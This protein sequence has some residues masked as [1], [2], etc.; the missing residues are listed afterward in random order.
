MTSDHDPVADRPVEL[1]RFGEEYMAGLDPNAEL[2][3]YYPV[4][5]EKTLSRHEALR[6]ST[7][8]LLDWLKSGWVRT[9]DPAD[10]F[11]PEWWRDKARQPAEFALQQARQ[12]RTALLAA[13]APAEILCV[14]GESA[15]TP[16][17]VTVDADGLRWLNTSEGDGSTPWALGV[18]PGV[19]AFRATMDANEILDN[20]VAVRA[21]S[22]LI[23]HGVTNLLPPH[24]PA[25][26]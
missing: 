25:P 5:V 4:Q 1:A 16:A 18:L 26:R 22:D 11:A 20:P 12:T 23:D 6:A 7:D 10:L 17:G 14:L 24:A 9:G 19:R 3:A 13:I 8:E 2:F 15:H 21:I